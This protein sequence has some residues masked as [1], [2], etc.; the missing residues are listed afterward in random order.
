MTFTTAKNKIKI[1]ILKNI[2]KNKYQ[3]KIKEICYALFPSKLENMESEAKNKSL[4]Q[5][6]TALMVEIGLEL[7]HMMQ[8]IPLW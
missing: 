4:A 5:D 8:S 1:I 3:Q 7:G 2:L 6:H